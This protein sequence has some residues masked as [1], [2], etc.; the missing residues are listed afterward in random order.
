MGA[1]LHTTWVVCCRRWWDFLFAE[2]LGLVSWWLSPAP[3]Q[4]FEFES[5]FLLSAAMFSMVGALPVLPGP[6][7]L[8]WFDHIRDVGGVIDM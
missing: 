7:Q 5:T 6:C 3:L 2:N 1:L 8:L 4:G